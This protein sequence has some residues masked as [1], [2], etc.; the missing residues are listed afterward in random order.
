MTTELAILDFPIDEIVISKGN[1]LPSSPPKI[2][3]LQL[4]GGGAVKGLSYLC[5]PSKEESLLLVEEVGHLMKI[6]I[7]LNIKYII[8]IQF[9][10]DI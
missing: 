7:N 2:G 1:C 3:T 9:F 4:V 8:K 6:I 5:I 10:K